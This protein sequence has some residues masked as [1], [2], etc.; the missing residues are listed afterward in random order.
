[1][2]PVL[3]CHIHTLSSG[4]AYSTVSE[5]ARAANERG[6]TLI[7]MTD[8]APAMPGGAHPFHFQNL[9]VLPRTLHGVRL[10]RGTEANILDSGG[11]LDLEERVL[12]ELDL[13]IASLHVPCYRSGTREEN[14]RAVVAAMRNPLVHVLGHPDDS[15]I[16]LDLET[17][18]KVA[19][20][21]GTLLEV[22][23]SSLM[24]TSFRSNA[25]ENY[26][27]LLRHAIRYGARVLLDS[28]AHFHGDVGNFTGALPL[29]EACGVP[30]ELVANVSAE[31]L[32]S[33]LKQV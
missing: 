25:R 11:A 1:M 27:E 4:H 2:K 20:E 29:V 17:V 9:R 13:V 23:N 16:P 30:E 24:P 32:M 5:C 26:Q 19:A 10:L 22:N 3:D 14:T 21:T 15:R 31:R 6:L 8:H 7:A 33:F 28:D 12:R 18:A